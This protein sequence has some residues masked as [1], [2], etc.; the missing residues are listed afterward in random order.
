VALSMYV[1]VAKV[2]IMR[3]CQLSRSNEHGFSLLEMMAVVALILVVTAFS[4]PSLINAISDINLRYAATNL[5][6]LLQTARIQAVKRNTFYGIQPTTLP[7]GDNAY[8]VNLQG[9]TYVPGNPLL[10]LG[11]Q[12]QVFQGIGSGA[13][14]EG[15]FVAGLGFAAIGGGTVPS[16]NARGLPCSPTLANTCP[17][18]AG[19]GFVLFLSR[20]SPLGAIRWASVVVTPSGR[21]QVWSCDNSGNWVQR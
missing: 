11:S 9:P 3:K 13:A 4:V 18:N 19:Q 10:P 8:F 12:L 5:S 6:G 17:Q 20:T 1:C 14:N 2:V 16:F 21:I 7:N 15:T